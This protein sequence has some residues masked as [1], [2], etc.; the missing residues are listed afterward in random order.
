LAQ[1]DKPAGRE[2]GAAGAAGRSGEARDIRRSDGAGTRQTPA[3]HGRTAPAATQEGPDRDPLS[4]D[5]VQEGVRN[6][7]ARREAA[8]SGA[9]ASGEAAGARAD[10][11]VASSATPDARAPADPPRS[12]PPR[13]AVPHPGGAEAA[14]VETAAPPRR[15]MAAPKAAPRPPAGVRAAASPSRAPDGAWQRLGYAGATTTPAAGLDPRLRRAADAAGERGDTYAFL[16]MDQAPT[17]ETERA[18]R[19]LGA[20]PLGLHGSALKVRVPLRRSALEAVARLPGARSL[21]YATVEQRVAPDLSGAIARLGAEVS[22]FP[23]IVNLFEDDRGGA[24]AGRIRATGAEVGRY[25]P[26]LRAYEALASAEQVRALAGLDFVL[27]LEAERRGGGGHDQSMPTNGVDYIRAA[28]FLGAGTVLG[29]LDSGFMAGGAAPTMH[30]DLNKNGC[31]VNF[32]TDAAGVWNDQNGHGTHVLA[33]ISGTGTADARFRGAATALGDRD[34]IRAAKIWNSANTGQNGWLRDAMDYMAEATSCDA[35]R[36]SLVNLSGGASGA[37]QTGTDAESRKLDAKVWE[38]RQAY[39]VCSGNSGP[40]AQTIWSPGV[41]KNALTVGN[42]EDA[43]FAVVGELRSTSSRGPTGDKRMKPNVTATGAV[44]TSALAGTPDRYTDKTGCSMA[45]PHVTGIAASLLEHYPDFRGRPHLLRAHLMAS[46]V[47][48]RDAVVPAD[49]DGGGR[50]D[51]GLGRVSD[52]QSHWAHPDRNGWTGHW[53]WM[54]VTDRAWGSFDVEV[55]AGASRLAVV[56]TWDEPEASAGAS[57][58]VSNDIDLW[59]DL[60]ADCAPDA[61]GQCGEWA[62]QSFDDNTEYLIIDNPPPGRYRLKAVNWRAP[63]TGLPVA[64][65]AKVV[66][67]DPTPAATLAAT[68][69]TT[70]SP[71]GSTFT[72]TTTVA[73]PAYEAYGVQV[74]VPTMPAG[75]TLLDTATTREDGVAM[76]FPNARSLTLGSVVEGD[77]RSAVWRFRVDAPGPHTI[78]FRSWSDNGGTAFQSVTVGP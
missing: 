18:L 39:I 13:G 72:V 42:V 26:G 37:G 29:I 45:T 70:S 7:Q 15:G 66:R 24:F 38:T 9:A 28:G 14:M 34:R 4:L 21:S 12:D 74:S 44:V 55:P 41:A 77:A 50:D 48:H 35:P 22:R 54:T 46:S 76:D 78:R 23:V 8:A 5:A 69:S 75:L 71:V 60:G 47:L 49:N 64:I 1:S 25:D 59:A 31:G 62:S 67:G 43:G 10:R 17:A 11:A 53:A 61:L 2:A 73:T 16:L 65:A 68:P 33:T 36:P 19:G 6:F 56:L 52:Y 40:N 3:R 30:N 63:A 32:T 51:Y 27:F 20:E 57:Q 58:A